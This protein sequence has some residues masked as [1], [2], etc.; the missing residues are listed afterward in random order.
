AKDPFLA[1][2]DAA[3]DDDESVTAGDLE[4]LA[5]ASRGIPLEQVERE[6]LA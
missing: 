1:R 5:D 4:A 3:P 6:W 2:L